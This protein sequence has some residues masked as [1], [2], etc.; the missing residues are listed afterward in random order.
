MLMLLALFMGALHWA[1]TAPPANL[2]LAADALIAHTRNPLPLQENSPFAQKNASDASVGARGGMGYVPPINRAQE[3]TE[4]FSSTNPRSGIQIGNR[5]LIEIPNS[6][7][8]KVFSGATDAEVQRYFTELTGSSQLPV[9]RVIP[10]KG[11]IYVVDTP[12]G[13]FTLRDFATSSGQTGSTWTIDLPKGAT[14]TTYNPEI[15]FLR[16]TQP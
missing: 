6:G 10:G 13:N 15:K 16:S 3:I 9:P 4:L 14:G 5:S 12:Q 2:F 1:R 8:A 7:N 11:T